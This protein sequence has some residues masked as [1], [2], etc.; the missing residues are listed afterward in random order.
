MATKIINGHDLSTGNVLSDPIT[1]VGTI[2]LQAKVSGAT[3]QKKV[4]ISIL[5]KEGDSNYDPVRNENNDEINFSIYGD[6]GFRMQLNNINAENVKI[7]ATVESGAVG[8]L[9][10]EYTKD[11]NILT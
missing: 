6:G 7:Q 10:V 8:T 3:S 4:K 11:T 2:V 1:D 9:T 5:A